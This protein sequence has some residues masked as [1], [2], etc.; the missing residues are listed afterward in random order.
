MLVAGLVVADDPTL[1]SLFDVLLLHGGRTPPGRQSCCH[2]EAVEGETGV[3][4]GPLRQFR[5][6][7]GVDGQTHRAQTS[8]PVAEGTVDQ[9]FQGRR[10]QGFQ[11]IDGRSGDQWRVD[12]EERILGRCSDQDDEPIFNTGEKRVLLA[13]V[14]AVDLVEEEHSSSL[15]GLEPLTGSGQYFPHILHP[16]RGRRQSFEGGLGLAGDEAG[17]RG[18]ARTRR[19]PEDHRHRSPTFHHPAKGGS[20]FE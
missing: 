5:P 15:L 2:L 9:L 20:S 13:L 11:A 1:E 10:G 18:L 4:A 7:H 17:K 3:A 12:L 8:L 16:G 19:A 14:E 6:H